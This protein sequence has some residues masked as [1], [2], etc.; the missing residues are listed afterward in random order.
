MQITRTITL[1]AKDGKTEVVLKFS[2][3]SMDH[4]CISEDIAVEDW[5]NKHETLTTAPN[6]YH[7]D[8]NDPYIKEC[9]VPKSTTLRF[10]QLNG[11]GCLPGN[12]S[13]SHYDPYF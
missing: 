9:I 4:V 2:N 13:D 5:L 3:G 11:I 6:A 1:A 7:I 10:T 8:R 12:W